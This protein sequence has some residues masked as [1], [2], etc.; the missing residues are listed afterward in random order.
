VR[1]KTQLIGE[2]LTAVAEKNN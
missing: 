2:V 1:E